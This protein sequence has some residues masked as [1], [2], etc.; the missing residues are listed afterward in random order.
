MIQCLV[1][2]QIYRYILVYIMNIMVELCVV[3]DS[4]D[5]PE[6]AHSMKIIHVDA[7][8]TSDRHSK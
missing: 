3:L 8:R 1:A 5:R 4:I 6:S 7:E 2:I